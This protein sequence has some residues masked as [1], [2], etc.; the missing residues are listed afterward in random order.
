MFGWY[1]TR[2][3]KKRF[4][5]LRVERK[6]IEILNSLRD[7]KG[8]ILLAMNHASWWDPLIGL[9]LCER[10]LPYHTGSAP[11][12]MEQWKTFRFMRRLGLFGLDPGHPDALREMVDH[13][14]GLVEARPRTVFVITPQ[15]AFTDVRTPIRVRPGLATLA[16]R[17]P[18]AKLYSVACEYAFWTDQR[19]EVFLRVT[20]VQRPVVST[21]P[22]WQ[23]AIKRGMQQNQ[24]ELGGLVV[25][26]DP[27]AFDL[28]VACS[29]SRVN[30]AYDLMAKIRGRSTV[31]RSREHTA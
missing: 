10:F 14:S 23:R 13:V 24:D 21:I 7:D 31:V 9:V 18:H 29:G 5:A 15:G 8:P 28:L 17:L 12:D 20:Q 16:T 19:P 3:I 4:N 27:D 6:S 25:K 1:T 26:R 11:M 30:P 22:G 2:L